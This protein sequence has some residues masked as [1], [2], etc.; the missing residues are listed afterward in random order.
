MLKSAINI[1][2]IIAGVG[3]TLVLGDYLG[4]KFGRWRLAS[5]VAIILLIVVVAFAIL[6]AVVLAR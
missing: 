4:Y 5:T 1:L 2:E 6:S 3:A